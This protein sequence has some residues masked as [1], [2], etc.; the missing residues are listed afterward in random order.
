MPD[1]EQ[2]VDLNLP[3]VDPT[4]NGMARK[5]VAEF[6]GVVDPVGAEKT[7]SKL[8]ITNDPPV[9]EGERPGSSKAKVGPPPTTA[10]PFILSEC[11]PPVPAK[12]V[13]KIIK[14]DYVEMAE[15]L[16][17]N[18][19]MERR[20][21]A[22][23][24]SACSGTNRLQ[25]RE[26]PDFLSWLQC[27]G[28]YASIVGNHKPKK[29][30]QLLAYQTI[31]IREAR[32]CGGSGWQGYDAMFR[33]MAA[34]VPDT[35]W[36]QL[37]SALYT[38]TFMA[39]QNGRGKTCQFCLETD[40]LSTDCAMAPV[41]QAG[42]VAPQG[43]GSISAGYESR[44]QGSVGIGWI[45]GTTNL[46]Q[47]RVSTSKPG[48]GGRRGGYQSALPPAKRACYAWNEGACDFRENCR[49]RHICVKC[50]GDHPA[51]A[52]KAIISKPSDKAE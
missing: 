34:T 6:L 30:R 39:Q 9:G 51:V 38:V 28:T 7:T 26:V 44:R 20:G 48:R 13:A 41:R 11:L 36:G 8:P 43:G 23:D 25:R 52:C 37:N 2:V 10:Q 18:I 17:D 49:Y 21:A 15:L 50:E 29:I 5:G 35:D 16:R 32:R 40:H 3:L 42:R 24:T 27:F 1:L 22:V 19:E 33:Q 47:R 31:M 14:G 45:P 12:L 46:E 4:E